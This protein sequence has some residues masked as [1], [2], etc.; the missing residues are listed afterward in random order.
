MPKG[1]DVDACKMV[2]YPPTNQLLIEHLS[3]A[4][5][6]LNGTGHWND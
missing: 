4:V 2:A 6:K 5:G 3:V 1:E